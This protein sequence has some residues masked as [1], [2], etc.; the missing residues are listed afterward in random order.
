MARLNFDGRRT[1]GKRCARAAALAAVFS[2]TLLCGAP[3]GL[4]QDA[5]PPAPPPSTGGGGGGT[6]APPSS[7]GNT[8]QP[9]IPQQQQN[10]PFGRDRQGTFDRQMPV[11]LSGRVMVDDGTPA[12]PQTVIER[13]CNG[14]QPRPEG[15]TDSK[16]RFSIQLG[17][18]MGMLADASVSNADDS[19][20]SPGRSGPAVGPPGT[21]GFSERDLMGCEIRASYPGYRSQVVT[22]SGRRVLDNPDVGTII[23]K[24]LGNVEGLMTSMTSMEA[25]KEAKKAYEKGIGL[26]KKGKRDEAM[27]EVAKSVELYP[28]YAAAWFDLGRMHE[29]GQND[30]EARKAYEAAV[31]ADARFVPPYL[32]LAGLAV[33]E[34][35]WQEAAD[36]SDRVLRLNPF[37][38][39]SVYLYSAV[40]NYNLQK[41]DV[42]E[43]AAREGIKQD[44]QHRTPKLLHILGVILAQREDYSS[45]ADQ[46]KAYLK[47]AP[48]ARDASMVQNQLAEIEKMAANNQPAAAPAKP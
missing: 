23:M 13:V 16:G 12:P 46:M 35:K 10:D 1:T 15:Y 7:G 44:E 11:F 31:K 32:Q 24:R 6:T 27:R 20:G 4:A 26:I 45:A 3:A 34:Q 39:P 40:A 2:M 9:G 48:N 37:D 14:G 47:F 33:R 19:F 36:T 29:Q 21:R 38:Y 5:P 43:K 28:R 30:A 25:P 42:A 22:L 41:M 8:R 17:A 18:N